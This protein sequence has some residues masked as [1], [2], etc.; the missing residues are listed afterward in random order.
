MFNIIK[1]LKNRRAKRT[2]DIDTKFIK[3]A[4]PIISFF[5]SELFTLCLSTAT[6]PDLIKVAEAITI[7]KRGEKEKMTNYRPTVYHFNLSS[8]KYLKNCYI[9]IYI[10][11]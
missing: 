10:T 9:I 8:I 7:F 2:L 4:N 1:E 3:T 11:T 5:L 6:Y